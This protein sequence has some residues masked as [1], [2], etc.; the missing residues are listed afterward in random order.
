MNYKISRN[1][2]E[3][4]PY[5]LEELQRYIEEGSILPNDYAYNG[6]EWVPVSQL[7]QDPQKGLGAA[8]SISSVANKTSQMS[9]FEGESS[10]KKSGFVGEAI[11]FFMSLLRILLGCFVLMIAIAL[12]FTG[13]GD[14]S[15]MIR[16]F[17]ILLLIFGFLILFS[18]GGSGRRGGGYL[19][20]LGCSSC[21][22]WL[23]GSSDSSCGG[24]CSSCGG[25]CGGCGGGD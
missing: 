3:Y 12:V 15:L 25:G 2:Q 19:G 16:A 6:M 18:K 5:T 9:Y 24:G 8:H 21:S 20:Y 4:G 22:S 13:G 17:G 23:S 11:S 7:L 1:G 10:T 14:G